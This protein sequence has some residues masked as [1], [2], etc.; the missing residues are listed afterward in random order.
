MK[1]EGPS[2]IF[3]GTG[4]G[5]RK[6]FEVEGVALENIF[7]NFGTVPPK[8]HGKSH[9]KSGPRKFYTSW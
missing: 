5:P 7:D 2:K 8:M 6:N 4:S 3:W 9:G 1:S